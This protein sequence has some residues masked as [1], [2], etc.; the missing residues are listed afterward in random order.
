MAYFP[1][2]LTSILAAPPI[3]GGSASDNDK[4]VVMLRVTEGAS[5]FRCSGTVSY[6]HLTLPTI[7][8]V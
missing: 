7:L 5:A 4:A 3:I 2:V 1:V 8:R 6:T